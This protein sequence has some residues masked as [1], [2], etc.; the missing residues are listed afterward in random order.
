MTVHRAGTLAALAALALAALGCGEKSEPPTTGPVITQTTGDQTKLDEQAVRTAAVA[1]LI[2][3]DSVA[4]CDEGITPRL[5]RQGYR[6]RKRCLS[7]RKPG[8][9]AENVSIDSLRLGAAGSADVVATAKGGA[10]RKGEKVTM[11]LDR[12]G[13]G[14]W[15]V[16]VVKTKA[17]IFPK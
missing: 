12:D 3:P 13:A 6:D 1:F 9:L 2:S 11:R 15:R 10:Y 5:L 4:V 7:A 14:V 8:K 16:D 17:P